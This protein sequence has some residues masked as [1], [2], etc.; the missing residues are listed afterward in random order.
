M[1][2]SALLK[3]FKA[4]NIKQL[5]L[6]TYLKIINNI[7]IHDNTFMIFKSLIHVIHYT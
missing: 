3:H 2:L 4:T 6:I 7:K 1:P 5:K